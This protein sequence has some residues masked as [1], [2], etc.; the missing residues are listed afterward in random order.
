V[1]TNQEEEDD[2]D[3]NIEPYNPDKWTPAVQQVH[4][5]HPMKEREYSHLHAM[6]MH[7]TMTQ[8]SLKKGLKKFEKVGEEAVSKE[9]LQL[10]MWDT[11]K[12]QSVKDLSSDQKKGALESLMFLKEKY[13][14]TIKGRTCTDGRN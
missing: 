8:Y 9:L 3:P 6:I 13:D 12:P 2:E 4:G 7:H 11:F 5:L 10:P 14:G 1:A